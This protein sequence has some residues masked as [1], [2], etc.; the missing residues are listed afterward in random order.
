M[1]DFDCLAGDSS[2]GEQEPPGIHPSPVKPKTKKSTKSEKSE[3]A[4][5]CFIDGKPILF[6]GKMWRG[7][8]LHSECFNGVRCAVRQC[9]TKEAR[10]RLTESAVSDPGFFK[11]A[12][13]P[14]VSED[15]AIRR[16]AVLAGFNR[17]RTTTFTTTQNR[18]RRLK[19]TMRMFKKFMKDN[20]DFGSEEAEG[21]FNEKAGCTE[22]RDGG[23]GGR[24]QNVRA[25]QRGRGQN[26][27][28]DRGQR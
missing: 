21:E 4:P 8:H 16:R 25:R 19:L 26:Q 1:S 23:F 27:R 10:M 28:Q 22:Q 12:V 17:K 20:E 14:L 18:K 24:A 3:T 15:G 13:A 7:M 6:A 9:A 2:G 5:S 11:N